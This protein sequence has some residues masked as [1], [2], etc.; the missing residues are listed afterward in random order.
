MSHFKLCY[1][2]ANTNIDP[3]YGWG[4]E[5]DIHLEEGFKCKPIDYS[6]IERIIDENL[7]RF[8]YDEKNY[9][10]YLFLKKKM[11]K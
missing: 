5:M 10:K 6:A 7:I 1:L 9:Q 11:P 3:F 8:E 2:D 4:S